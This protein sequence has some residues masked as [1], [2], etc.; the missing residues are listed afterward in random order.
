MVITIDGP[1]GAGKSTVARAVAARLGLRYLDTGAMYRALTLVAL[2]R[3]V[4][5]HD[6]ERLAL[7]APLA[8]GRSEDP[9]LRTPRVDAA[10]S[11]VAAHPAV[12][13]AMRDAQRAF[14]AEDDAV[15]EGR[16][17]GAVVWPAAGLKVWLDADPAVRALRRVAEREDG[18]AAAAL[19][20]R[21]RS[22]AEQTLRAPDAVRIDTG[23]LTIDQVV[24][25]VV[26][27]AVERGAAAP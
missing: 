18:S 3:E 5:L 7:L 27:L 16:D 12:R 21:D 6:A 20:A 22:D 26:E 25:R 11:A 23:P 13:S 2:E 15:A 17:I 8:A 4:P 9:G 24:E 1:A 14:L 19:H 10:V